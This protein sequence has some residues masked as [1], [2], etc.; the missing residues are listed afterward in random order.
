MKLSL[1]GSK[2][3]PKHTL[4]LPLMRSNNDN[5][6]EKKPFQQGMNNHLT[7]KEMLL[8]FKNW[9]L[10][11]D[12]DYGSEPFLHKA[13]KILI[14]LKKA[15]EAERKQSQLQDEIYRIEGQRKKKFELLR[16]D[17]YRDQIQSLETKL[18]IVLAKL[19]STD[20]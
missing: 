8:K 18:D 3:V 9:F 11:S 2:D 15:K 10:R 4:T 14:R 13:R 19:A 17:T 20:D 5:V 16:N 7:L 6:D 1:F 12:E